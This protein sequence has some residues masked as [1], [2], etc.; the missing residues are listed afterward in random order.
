MEGVA[1][2]AL[3]GILLTSTDAVVK[4]AYCKDE[5][6]GEGIRVGQKVYCSEPCAF[7]GSQ[8]TGSICGSTRSSATALHYPSAK[9]QDKNPC[10]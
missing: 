6:E 3:D 10:C 4:C 5:I 9:R 2:K 8:K 7:E 1:A